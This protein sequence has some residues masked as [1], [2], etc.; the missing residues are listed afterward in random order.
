MTR[1]G[2]LAVIELK[3]SE[4]IHLALQAVDCWLRVRLHH[5]QDDFQR[6]GYLP[7]VR[8]APRPRC[9]SW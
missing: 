8:L 2:R 4:D 6:F 5:Q 7:E 3:A 1:D 9:C